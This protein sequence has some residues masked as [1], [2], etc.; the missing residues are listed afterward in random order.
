MKDRQVVT[1]N[2]DKE[3]TEK[4]ASRDDERGDVE[5]RQAVTMNAQVYTCDIQRRT[6]DEQ[7]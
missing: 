2:G 5:D 4:Q 1:T 3:T 7:K 6:K